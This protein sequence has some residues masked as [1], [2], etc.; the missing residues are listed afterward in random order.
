MAVAFDLPH[1]QAS[2]LG[3]ALDAFDNEVRHLWQGQ[4]L[5]A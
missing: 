3:R 1:R 2:R 4:N 5:A